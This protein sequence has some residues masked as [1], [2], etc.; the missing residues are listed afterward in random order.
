MNDLTKNF[1][2]F[3]LTVIL[4]GISI[5]GFIF[6]AKYFENIFNII[7]YR[8]CDQLIYIISQSAILGAT[9]VFNIAYLLQVNTHSK[10]LI[11]GL[12]LINSACLI[13]GS[14]WGI[15]IRFVDSS[16]ECVGLFEDR[17]PEFIYALT[18][19]IYIIIIIT[20]LIITIIICVLIDR[21]CQF[22]I[23]YWLMK[24]CNKRVGD[25]N[26]NRYDIEENGYHQI[27]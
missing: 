21:F 19:M 1:I 13:T 20:G 3:T 18:S 25:N 27:N 12:F 24:C 26:I 15:L 22:K 17:F 5:M 10:F 6:T 4:V 14:I 8:N 23:S 7:I 16:Q 9:G 11:I 2:V